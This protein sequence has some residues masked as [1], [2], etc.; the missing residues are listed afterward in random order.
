ML[1]CTLGLYI[2][3]PNDY[4][5]LNASVVTLKGNNPPS[6]FV[7]YTPGHGSLM[8]AVEVSTTTIKCIYLNECTCRVQT[9]IAFVS[10][11]SVWFFCFLMLENLS[12]Y[13]IWRMSAFSWFEFC[14]FQHSLKLHSLTF[15]GSS[16]HI[17]F[18]I[19]YVAI[20]SSFSA[21][22]YLCLQGLF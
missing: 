22:C 12:K 14:F 9:R 1:D 15:G 4:C 8:S 17:L 3:N 13:V 6:F 20:F 11:N 10:L 19:A 5:F 18:S 7:E 2:T 16:H 21:F